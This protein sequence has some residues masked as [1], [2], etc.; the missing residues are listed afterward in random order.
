[1]AEK[2]KGVG[3]CCLKHLLAF[4]TQMQV[5][6][7]TPVLRRQMQ[8]DCL[9]FETSLFYLSSSRPAKATYIVKSSYRQM[10]GKR[11]TNHGLRNSES[12]VL[13]LR[14]QEHRR[15]YLAEAV[16]GK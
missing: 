15:Q 12:Y 7:A 14:A 6:L 2:G 11:N 16:F 13:A 10:K 3:N 5:T 8:E 4:W 1:M 9:E